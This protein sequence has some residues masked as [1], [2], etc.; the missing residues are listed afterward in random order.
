[1][2]KQ[3]PSFIPKVLCVALGL[4][5]IN[6]LFALLPP[7]VTLGYIREG[8]VVELLSAA[9]YFIG[10]SILVYFSLKKEIASS[11]STGFLVLLLG[12]RELDFHD[13]FT[14]MGIFK[15]KF[16]VSPIVP[17]GEKIFITILVLCLLGFIFWYLKKHGSSFISQL[18][19]G[20]AHV[21]LTL[22]GIGSMFLSKFLDSYSELIENILIL[23]NENPA[24]QS[25]ILEETLELAIPVF[26]IQAIFSYRK[27]FNKVT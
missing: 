27:Y 14:T 17:I 23:M 15:T 3:T 21:V 8:G 24:F 25:Q 10:A 4:V 2:K 6:I 18:K 16:Y 22:C 19:K 12:L 20:T 26:F 9:G 13:R 7:E 5:A 1:M 11:Y